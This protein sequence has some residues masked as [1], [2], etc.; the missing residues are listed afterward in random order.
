M[1]GKDNQTLA[2]DISHDLSDSISR[3]HIGICTL[4]LTSYFRYQCVISRFVSRFRSLTVFFPF[5][6]CPSLL[7]ENATCHNGD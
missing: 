7:S 2:L 1:E 3:S 6:V 5:R 4:E